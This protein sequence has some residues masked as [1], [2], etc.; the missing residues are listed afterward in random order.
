MEI[1]LGTIR[2]ECHHFNNWLLHLETLPET[3]SSSL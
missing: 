1:G 2:Q 3:L